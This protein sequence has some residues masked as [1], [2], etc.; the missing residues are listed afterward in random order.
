MSSSAPAS[1]SPAPVVT[2][3]GEVDAPSGLLLVCDPSSLPADLLEQL[4]TPGP[5][6]LPPLGAV[7]RLPGDARS[8]YL[9]GHASEEAGGAFLAVS[10]DDDGAWLPLDGASLAARW[11]DVCPCCRVA[12]D[13]D[14]LAP[15]HARAATAS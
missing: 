3:C 14:A 1:S 8:V 6:G 7:V 15:A 5:D 10:P 9:D 12:D 4:T 2:Y 13:L 11:D